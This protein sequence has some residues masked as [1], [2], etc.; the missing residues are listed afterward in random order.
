MTKAFRIT[1][2]TT[3]TIRKVGERLKRAE[4]VLKVGILKDK[5]GKPKR[6]DKGQPASTTLAQVASFHEFGLGVPRR[7]FLHDTIEEERRQIK[8]ALENGVE[9]ASQDLSFDYEKHLKKLGVYMKGQIQRRISSGIAPPLD[10]RTIKRKG[11]ATPLID[12]GQLR[13]AI[14]FK[15]ERKGAA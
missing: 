3:D 14:H 7:S 4:S 2:D 6:A 12:T 13:S 5:G 15:V 11:S 8:R 1:K 10:E 9:L